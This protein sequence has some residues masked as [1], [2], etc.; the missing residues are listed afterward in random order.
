MKISDLITVHDAARAIDLAAIEQLLQA[1]DREGA[2]LTL[3]TATQLGEL[4]GEYVTSESQ[5]VDP[6][7]T[8]LSAIIRNGERGGAFLVRGSGGSGKSHL[9]AATALLLRSHSARSAFVSSHPAYDDLQRR[10]DG[11]NHLV[12]PIPLA[13]HRGHE[14]H[15]E[16]IVFDRTERALR[17]PSHSV[18]VALSEQSY[19]LDRIERHI[20][21]RYEEDLDAYTREHAASHRTWQSLCKKA[22]AQAVHV[23]R[24]FAQV[25]QYPLDFRQSRVERLSR[26]LEVARELHLSGIVWLLDDLNEFLSGV[27]P[28]AVHGDCSFLDFMGQRCK[29]A[30]LFMVA[31]LNEGLEQLTSVEPYLL[32]AIR[33]SYRT[34]LVLSPQHMRTVARRRVIAPVDPEEYVR[35][36]A[37]VRT[38]YQAAFGAAT[39]SPDE[40]AE[41]YPLHPAAVRCLESIAERFFGAADTLVAFMQD[42]LDNTYLAGV[43]QRD[44]R[45]LITVDDIFDYLRPRIAAHPEVSA[46]VYEVLDYYQKNAEEVYPSDPDLCVRLV[47]LLIIFRLANMPA[48][49][50]VLVESLGLDETGEAC[51]D[52]DGV[53]AALEAMRLSGNF[54]DVRRS[55]ADGPPA[56]AVDVQTSVSENLRRR[57]AAAKASFGD[58]D[59]HVWR[60]VQ[61]ACDEASFPLAHLTESRTLEVQW[62]NAFR[63][64]AAELVDL[65]AFP[66][67]AINE[68]VADLADPSTVE[69]VCLLVTPLADSA[70][71]K[72]AWER[73]CETTP[74]T[75]WSAAVLAWVPRKL[76]PQELDRLKEFT[77][78]ADLLEDESALATESG[79]RDQLSEMYGPGLI[80]ARKIVR[81][82]YYQGEVFSPFGPVGAAAD[83]E[84]VAGDWAATLQVI[85]TPA[86]ERVFPQF[87]EFAPR[88]PILSRDQIDTLVDE[89]IRPGQLT[90]PENDPRAEL[91][92]SF[93]L[94][95]GLVT[96]RDDTCTVDV[97]RSKVA[98]EVV[99]RV[100][101]RDQTPLHEA[102][103]PIAC[104]D[105]AQHLVKSPLGL[106]PEMFELVVA[107]LIRTG[108][109]AGQRERDHLLRMEDIDTPLSGS[110]QYVARPPLLSPARWQILSRVCRIALDFALPAPDFAVQQIAWEFLVEARTDHLDKARDVRERLQAHIERLEQR[111][112]QW[113]ETFADIDALQS[114]FN[115]VRPEL[116]PAIGL[117]EFVNDVEG[118]IGDSQGT[119]RLA[120]LFRRM[121]ALT[122]YLD[123]LASEV[124]AVRDY[125]LSDDLDLSGSQDLEGRRQSVLQLVSSGEQIL[126]EEMNLRRLVQI[127]LGSYKR[128]YLSW[129]GRV[130]R[131]PVFDQYRAVH[132]SAEMRAL[133]QLS[134]VHV[135]VRFTADDMAHRIEEQVGRRCLRSDLSDALDEAPVCPDCRLRM[136]QEP[137][138]VEVDTLL[139]EA[140]AAVRGHLESL[141]AAGV[142]QRIRE[143]AASV[144]SR[145]D[146]T[147]RLEQIAQ[148]DPEAG[149]RQI[150]TLF[151]DD[152]IAHVNRALTGTRMAP[153]DLGELRK[154]MEGRTLTKDE[155][156]TVFRQWLEGDGADLD[157]DGLLQIDG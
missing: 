51:F 154:L 63:C 157:D 47:R 70:S 50:P 87:M 36:T 32:N 23:A 123:K 139:D 76:T 151:T 66:P 72:A 106:P 67:T 146:I 97:S 42:L 18:A 108:Y 53:T 134:K 86:F 17:S 31:A 77:A 58:G 62:Q 119:S 40:L 60:R 147:A 81:G 117:E 10:F 78:I 100:R 71:Q 125:M 4:L 20:V 14:E 116:P 93:L 75:R 84:P 91:V 107:A 57:I 43:L 80:Q 35:A 45:Q 55:A 29:I 48:P 135:D 12:V 83:L 150:L 24:Q 152:T 102:G 96:L 98:S 52:T 101:Q 5:P 99:A 82:A 15:L 111:P 124:V 156:Q 95:L 30:P 27:G 65:A 38:A 41:S 141:C 129:H 34:D 136:Q 142:Q 6:L 105:L 132:Q 49:V 127:F 137:Q 148:L 88:R 144:G 130:Y 140:R 131:S 113:S 114:T 112:T 13:E 79:L 28:K 46:Y 143:Y 68:Y 33:S 73:L 39:F 64:V 1:L 61:A 89:I 44:H 19:A 8:V 9:L 74:A 120:G 133:N 145:G 121:D 153:R 118:F 11:K 22:P 138:L 2:D 56:Y 25:I 115:C 7:R 109:L 85:T 92:H 126:S 90:L 149:P 59:P 69:D 110:M 122:S 128:A 104:S 3:G 26:L 16:D 37:E 54:V 155:A 21:P 94:P 103:R